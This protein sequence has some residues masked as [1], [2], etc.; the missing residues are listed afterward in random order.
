MAKALGGGLPIGAM[1]CSEKVAKSFKPGDHGTTFGGNPLVTEVAEMTFKKI[2][3]PEMFSEVLKKGKII[4]ECL[5][6]LNNDFKFF[7][8][9][10]G[11]GLMIGAVLSASLKNN[12]QEIVSECQ[13]RGVL[14]LSAGPNV[15]RFLPPLNINEEDLN[16]GLDRVESAL[17]Y[18]YKKNAS[19]IK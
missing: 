13:K 7:D 19:S 8:E 4:K 5:K 17:K 1:I 15:I 18:F 9:I 10:R 14:L 2:N 11:R 3:R 16:I 6:S 12:A